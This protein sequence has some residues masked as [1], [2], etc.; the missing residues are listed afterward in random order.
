MSPP[1]SDPSPT[2]EHAARILR[3]EHD[4]VLVVDG[5]GRGRVE[6][7]RFL[8]DDETGR[9]ITC[10]PTAV[11][12]A[13]EH[14]LFIP[15]ES[16]GA[17]Q[18]LTIP[19]PIERTG[20]DAPGASCDRWMTYFGS[21]PHARFVRYAID[22]GRMGA[23][24]FDGDALS[25]PNPLRSETGALCKR[26]NRLRQ[27]LIELCR[28]AG[29]TAPGSALLVGVDPFGIDVKARFGVLRFEFESPAHDGQDA[30]DRIERMLVHARGGAGD[31]R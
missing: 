23:A 2:P 12:N 1:P 8:L 15:D 10:L 6:P 5:M 11:V 13:D 30:A 18:L 28:N 4:A 14:V 9:P 17:L 24:V 3:R 31:G 27:E 19:E 25:I 20:G 26:F 22:C 21:P 7:C 16:E 29:C